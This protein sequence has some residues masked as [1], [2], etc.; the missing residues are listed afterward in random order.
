MLGA[1]FDTRQCQTAQT[2]KQLV[3][4]NADDCNLF[5]YTQ[6]QDTASFQYMPATMPNGLYFR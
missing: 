1:L 6:L 2:T 4:I 5:R 3:V